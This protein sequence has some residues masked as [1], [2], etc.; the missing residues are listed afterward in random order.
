MV[1]VIVTITGVWVCLV[2][3]V[4]VPIVSVL[5]KLHGLMLLILPELVITTLSVLVE[6]CATVKLVIANASQVTK[7][8]HA[9]VLSAPMTVL[10][11]VNALT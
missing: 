1:F 7:V 2:I 8:R 6:V 11:M 3:A 5:S 9:S 10:A 4:I